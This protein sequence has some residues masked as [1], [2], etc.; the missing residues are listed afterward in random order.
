VVVKGGWKL[1]CG[2]KRHYRPIAIDATPGAS[3]AG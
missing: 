2:W 1:S 3:L